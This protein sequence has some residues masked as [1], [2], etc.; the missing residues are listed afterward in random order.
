MIK[1]TNLEKDYP[2]IT[3]DC[4]RWDCSWKEAVKR[5]EEDR[6]KLETYR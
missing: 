3:K 5:R 6:V 2:G 4:K 1:L